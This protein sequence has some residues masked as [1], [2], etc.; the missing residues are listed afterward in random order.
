MDTLTFGPMASRIPL[1][2][3]DDDFSAAPHLQ[4]YFKLHGSIDIQSER[5]LTQVLGRD[6]EAEIDKHPILKA[7]HDQFRWR[8]NM[9]HA[10][11]M[12]IGYSFAD[13]HINKIIFEAAEEGSRFLS[14]I[15]WA[16]C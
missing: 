16:P 12:V 1:Y 8:L 14:L 13:H 15:Q 10:R 6:K 4:P 2:K 3:A 11:L 5:N 9:P 7:Y